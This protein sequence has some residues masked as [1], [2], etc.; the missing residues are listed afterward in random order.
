MSSN[1][2]SDV[3]LLKRLLGYVR[4]Y[5]AALLE[6]YGL[7]LVNALLNLIPAASLRY[8]FDFVISKEPVGFL[9][10]H[11]SPVGI[12]GDTGDQI[13]FSLYYFLAITLLILGANLIGVSM[14]RKGTKLAQFLLFNIKRN[15][16]SKLHTMS[17]S[18]FD[19]EQTGSIMS[20]SVGDVERIE[21][22]IKQSFNLLYALIHFVF[23]P[24]IM[25]G[26]SPVLFLFVL[27]P[28]PIIA[29][30]MYRIRAKLRPIYLEMREQQAR[31]GANIQEQIS[32][33]R[34][35]KAFGR[36][37]QSYRVYSRANLGYMRHVN[38]AMRTW[39]L[40]HQLVY[41]LNDF[42][43]IRNVD[44]VLVLDKGHLVEAGTAEE[45]EKQGGFFAEL[46]EAQTN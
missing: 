8:Y 30:A 12:I 14:H 5:R 3:N 21:Q 1:D 46:L 28:L 24:L 41:G 35:I 33:I 36:K 34:E 40:N 23:A 16:I 18:Y 44:R 4:S 2:I 32:G 29:F 45:L 7:F 38:N 9:G 43:M 27:P 11:F 31:I 26:M 13:R 37:R 19:R 17:I 15:V 22:M 39:S 10:L 20:R 6:V 25:I 42:A